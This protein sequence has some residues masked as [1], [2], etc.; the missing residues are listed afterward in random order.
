MIASR[1][2]LGGLF[3]LVGTQASAGTLR[4]S[5]TE[6]F[7]SIDFDSATGIAT[8]TSADEADPETGEIKPR[9]IAEGARIRRPGDWVDVP[10]LV[11]E[12]PAKAA[13]QE[14]EII[15]EIAVTGNGSDG[16]SDFVFPFEGRYGRLVGGCEAGKAP[17]YDM[18]EVYQDLGVVDS[19]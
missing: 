2:V 8:F 18:Y 16:M 1:L 11:L 4:C 6:P 10:K 7:F 12:V 3:A 9:I 14:P 17:A 5:F 15:L 13:G 19:P